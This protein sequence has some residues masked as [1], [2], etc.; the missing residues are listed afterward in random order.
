MRGASIVVLLITYIFLFGVLTN[1][2]ED[3]ERVNLVDENTY[4]L[5]QSD[6]SFIDGVL[7]FE[8]PN[9]EYLAIL[10]IP[11]LSNDFTW[12]GDVKIIQFGSDKHSNGVR[13]C[14]G[15]DTSVGD[16][17]NI[18]VSQI[19]GIAAER[20]GKNPM[21]DVYP[22]NLENYGKP[23]KEGQEFHFEIRK[24][25]HHV[26]F[27][28][29][30]QVVMDYEFPEEHDLFVEGEDLNLGFFASNC[31]YEVRNIEVYD[32]SEKITPETTTT[33]DKTQMPTPK[34]TYSSTEKPKVTHKESG[35]NPLVA[36]V[37]GIS[38]AFLIVASILYISKKNKRK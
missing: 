33:P 17:I 19:G 20:R 14:I 35:L 5:P 10:A 21:N 38:F 28:I 29:N 36:V 23:L 22:Y 16:Y 32:E 13:F 7:R 18:L 2:A 37:F 34:H 25:Q 6:V 4:L 24:N 27:K 31:M 12:S 15:H 11:G 1:A 3:K 8:N 9:R 26:V 30:D